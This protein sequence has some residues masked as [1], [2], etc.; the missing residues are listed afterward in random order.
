MQILIQQVWDPA[1]LTSSQVMQMLLVQ[2]LRL[3]IKSL[4]RQIGPHGWGLFVYLPTP[5]VQGFAYHEILVK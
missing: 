5:L 3:S 1:L 2:E 4:T